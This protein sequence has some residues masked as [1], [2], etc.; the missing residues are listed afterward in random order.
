MSDKTP[1]NRRIM[2]AIVAALAAVAIV[3]PGLAVLVPILRGNQQDA[4]LT[5][6]PT[7]TTP[8]VLTI[9]PLQL[10]SVNGAYVVRPGDCDPP[11]PTP[12][13]APL[14]ICDI[15]KSALF[16]LG[17]EV[18]TL[19]LTDVDSFLNPLTAK[20]I[21]Q[22]TMTEESAR[23]FADYTASHI[24]QQVA[25]VRAG[26]VV[27]APK[28]TEKIDGEVLQLSGEVTAEQAAEIARMLKD[29]A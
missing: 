12:P 28:I 24:D 16:D 29:E 10:R 19:Q 14:K 25:F 17:P 21:V 5:P 8:P 27:W 18:L 23:A 15:L 13:D 26:V 22:V 9:K 20:Q 11:P 3:V 6:T 2:I 1:R 7:T 4:M